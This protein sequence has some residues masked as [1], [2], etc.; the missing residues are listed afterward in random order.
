MIRYLTPEEVLRLH[1]L[2]VKRYGGT[3]GVRDWGLV[4]SALVRPRASFGD[5]QAYPDIF[6]KAAVL[7]Y[8]LVKNHGFVDGNK[9]TG[10]AVCGTFLI[11]NGY[12]L[13]VPQEAL[14]TFTLAI[15]EGKLSEVE[16]GAWLR[17][18]AK[19]LS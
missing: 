11:L 16:I 18:H 5:H 19:I 2:L 15:A 4:E 10:I 14:I 6:D 12:E 1:T 8:S 13:D 17:K 3:G 9:R 7:L